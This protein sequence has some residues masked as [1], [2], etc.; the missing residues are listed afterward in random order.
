[1]LS[2]LICVGSCVAN[3]YLYCFA[4]TILT[5]NCLLFSDALFKSN[6]HTMPIMFQKYFIIM[7]A[8]T[9]IPVYL[10]G[11]GI[12]RLSLESFSKVKLYAFYQE[13]KINLF[14]YLEFSDVARSSQLLFDVPNIILQ[15][16]N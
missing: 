16:N 9:Q 1:M 4:G 15:I 14:N 2:I 11:C 8:E 13:E 5:N 3:L 6:W 7:I 10:E 12:I